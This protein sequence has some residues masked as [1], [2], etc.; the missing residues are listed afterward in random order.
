MTKIKAPANLD[1]KAG[2]QDQI[3]N[4]DLSGVDIEEIQKTGAKG[5]VFSIDS[6]DYKTP[7]RKCS[8]C[9]AEEQAPVHPMKYGIR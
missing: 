3:I 4:F 9:P 5:Y 1:I 7:N 8:G 2:N 6:G